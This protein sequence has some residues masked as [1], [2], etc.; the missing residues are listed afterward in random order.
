MRRL[1]VILTSVA[2]VAGLIAILAPMELEAD[3]C[4]VKGKGKGSRNRPGNCVQKFCP[5]PIPP[6]CSVFECVKCGCDLLCEGGE[7]M[8]F[9]PGQAEPIPLGRIES[10]RLQ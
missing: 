2:L 8:R 4:P 6:G 10:E 7:V 5:D 3:P 1:T 9:V